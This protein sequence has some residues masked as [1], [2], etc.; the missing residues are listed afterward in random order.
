MAPILNLNLRKTSSSSSLE[1]KISKEHLTDVDCNSFGSYALAPYW[2]SYDF[3]ITY[4][5]I[6]TITQVN[7][8]SFDHAHTLQI[9]NKI[10]QAII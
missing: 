10:W 6:L 1:S 5:D 7:D 9:N 3:H 2:D 4:I 8:Q